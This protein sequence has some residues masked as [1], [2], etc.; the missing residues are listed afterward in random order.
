[1]NEGRRRRSS[2][3]A[4]AL[5]TSLLVL[6]ALSAAALGGPAVL[7]AALVATVVA[8]LAASPLGRLSGAHLNPA[9]T[10]G[11]RVV[12]RVGDRDL[13][14]YA[15]AQVLGA[16]GGALLF[17][18]AWGARATAIGDGVT[19]PRVPLGAALALEAAMTALLMATILAFACSPHR[20]RF[21]PLAIWPVLAVVVWAGSAP[22]GASLN[23]ARSAG[24]ALAA[25]DL[26]G[27]W[28]YLVAPAAGAVA[29]AVA[30]R[31]RNARAGHGTEGPAPATEEN[32]WPTSQPP[33]PAPRPSAA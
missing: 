11:F 17:R 13:A 12:G 9:V 7:T 16:L 19:H 6:G 18:V 8:L 15:A 27:L 31:T 3:S 26:E 4:E 5:G 25:A 29:V 30:W 2:W 24:P 32:P 14:G 28:L 1:V 22:T 23:P 20:M 21:T 10:L 33:Q